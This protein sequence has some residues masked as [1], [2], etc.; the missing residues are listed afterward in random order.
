MPALRRYKHAQRRSKLQS[1]YVEKNL[2][3]L[4]PAEG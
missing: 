1:S 2:I 3:V 4:E